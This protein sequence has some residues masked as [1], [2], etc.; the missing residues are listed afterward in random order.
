LR[1]FHEATGFVREVGPEDAPKVMKQLVEGIAFMDL[2][3]A[4]TFSF[5]LDEG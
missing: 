5:G 2:V 3:G 1:L 4:E